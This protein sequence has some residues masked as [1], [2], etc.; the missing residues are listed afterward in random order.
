MEGIIR[1]RNDDW[2]REDLQ[3]KL[4][5]EIQALYKIREI[6]G[7]PDL[8]LM[9]TDFIFDQ[10]P[11]GEKDMG[12]KATDEWWDASLAFEGRITQYTLDEFYRLVTHPLEIK[13]EDEQ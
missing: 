1:N 13:E 3:R 8:F 6:L 12:D 10:F 7:D 11:V 4:L 9:L 2:E 5:I